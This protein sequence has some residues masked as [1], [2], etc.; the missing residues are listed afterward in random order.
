[1]KAT[2]AAKPSS[3]LAICEPAEVLSVVVGCGGGDVAVV[4]ALLEVVVLEEVP[5]VVEG[6]GEDE[7]N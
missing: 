4:A 6:D 7:P 5:L 2:M 1:M 3:T